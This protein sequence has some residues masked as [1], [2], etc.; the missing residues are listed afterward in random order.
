MDREKYRNKVLLDLL[1]SP[2]TLLPTVAGLT[3]MAVAW[4]ADMLTGWPGMAGIGA[5]LFGLGTLASR[6][7][8]KGDDI[9]RKAFEELQGEQDRAH[10]KSL[11]DLDAQLQGD[12]DP[13]TEDA[14]RTLRA[15][16]Q[17]FQNNQEWMRNIGAKASFEIANSVEKL[18]DESIVF[19]KRS[20]E[21]WEAAQGMKTR[22]GRESLLD[23]RREILLEIEE[24]I[25]QLARTLDELRTMEV[26]VRDDDRLSRIRSELRESLDVASRVDER[27]HSLEQE[28]AHESRVRGD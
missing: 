20:F 6:W 1:T 28:L 18:F 16:Q 10:R 19:L 24:N 4:G 11:D 12:D 9:T 25:K 14:L 21:L 27:L 8:L 22:K 3:S 5:V 17:D 23:S 2:W 7:I 15:F 26:K 13:R